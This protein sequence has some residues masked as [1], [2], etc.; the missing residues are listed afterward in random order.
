M[1]A[2]NKASD[3]PEESCLRF[4]LILKAGRNE[5]SLEIR[6][7]DN[8]RPCFSFVVLWQP[9]WT[10]AI[11][12]LRTTVSRISSVSSKKFNQHW[13]GFMTINSEIY[14]VSQED[15]EAGTSHKRISLLHFF[16]FSWIIGLFL[17]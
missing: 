9:C 8:Q 11:F 2:L 13:R 14:C 12:P 17:K 10:D 6:V 15:Y 4:L 1:F 3:P 5:V 7:Q 16:F